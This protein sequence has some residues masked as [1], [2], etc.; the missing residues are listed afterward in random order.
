VV[1][2]LYPTLGKE[3]NPRLRL[4]WLPS[5]IISNQSL[6]L[7]PLHSYLRSFIIPT[8]NPFSLSL[9]T[10]DSHIH[11]NDGDHQSHSPM[12]LSQLKED[13]TKLK[14]DKEVAKICRTM[15]QWST[16]WR[17]DHSI[18]TRFLLLVLVD[19]RLEG[20]HNILAKD[21]SFI[22]SPTMLKLDLIWLGNKRPQRPNVQAW[23]NLSSLCCLSHN[24]QTAGPNWATLF[25]LETTHLGL[26]YKPKFTQF[27]P[28]NREI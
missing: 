25:F 14:E 22:I 23:A 8:S 2:L 17:R 24:F 11:H 12:L 10:L 19:P 3:N 6:D 15:M 4:E 26:S 5:G 18:L 7:S 16:S 1:N 20:P 21:V 9:V 27:G 13:H 28:V